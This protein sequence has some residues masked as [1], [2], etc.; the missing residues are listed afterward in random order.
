MSECY[1][2]P[3]GMAISNQARR[4]PADLGLSEELVER[5]DR[6]V[7][8]HP[9]EGVEQGWALWRHGYLVHAEGDFHRTVEVASLRKTWHAMIVGAAIQQGRIPCIDQSIGSW[10]KSLEGLHAQASWRHVLTQSAGFDYPYEDYPA[11]AP[12]EMWTYSDLNLVHLCNAL[13]SAYGKKD[14]YDEYADVAREAYFDAI[15]LEGWSTMIKWD[16]S[17]LMYD[18]VRFVFSLENLGRLGLLALAR[19][20]WN[21]VELIPS[22]FVEHLETKQTYGMQVNYDGPNDGKIG[23][24]Q[25]LSLIHI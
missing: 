7:K 15:G 4:A 1:F 14:F 16:R 25:Y 19:G 23:L 18:G 3:P 13:A 20:S 8:S 21:G 24:G 11:F 17:S 10:D 6:F 9:F 22:W 12:G 5:T 2:P